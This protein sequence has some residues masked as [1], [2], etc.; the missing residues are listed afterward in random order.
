[1]SGKH[2][3]FLQLLEGTTSI[4]PTNVSTH[5][6]TYPRTCEK[7]SFTCAATNKVR[8]HSDEKPVATFFDIFILQKEETITL[9]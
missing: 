4:L 2:L 7:V 8:T 3:P 6:T 9:S 1:M 5:I